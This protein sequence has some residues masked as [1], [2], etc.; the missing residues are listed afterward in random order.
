MKKKL[1]WGIIAP[2]GIGTKFAQ[3][4]DAAEDSVLYAIG[5]RDLSRAQSFAAAFSTEMGNP[6]KAYGSYAE[7]AADP[8]VEVV[9][10]ASPHPFHLE[11]A[12]L[13]IE[14]GKSVL[15]EKPF[16]VKAQEAEILTKAARDKKVFCMEAVW[17]RFLPA[18]QNARKA[19]RD[20]RIGDIRMIRGD[21]SFAADVGPEHR[22]LNPELAGGA[23]LDVGIYVLSLSSFFAGSP[24]DK[25]C[26]LAEIG[27]TGVDIQESISSA[28]DSGVVASL[29]CG[30][31][32]K[33]PITMEI[34]GTEGVLEIDRPFFCSEGFSIRNENGMERFDYP[35]NVNG[36]EHEAREVERC[37]AQGLLES[38]DMPLDES[39][40]IV[41]IM[42]E[43][44][45]EWG[46]KYPF[47]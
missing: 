12:M 42:D 13:C 39:L 18:M 45:A 44:R 25:V 17:S 41:K 43:L 3:G 14:N 8:E 36:Y 35:H 34:I 31:T 7:L 21:F 11:H 1:H 16:T 20:G 46:I 40:K 2:G 27:P 32:T 23:L 30:V 33:G 47:E 26:G 6:V 22:L 9:Y 24:P 5:S 10:I 19:I 15:V 37:L 28:W 29:T 4:L 38:P